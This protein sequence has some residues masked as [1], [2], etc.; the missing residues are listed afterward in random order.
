MTGTAIAIANITIGGQ[1]E[2]A[3]LAANMSTRSN[4]NGGITEAN[5]CLLS[6]LNKLAL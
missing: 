3:I 5:S 1:S 6:L 2:V 4:K